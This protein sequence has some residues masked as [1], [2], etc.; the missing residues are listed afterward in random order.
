MSLPTDDSL[1]D[2]AA[3]VASHT[4]FDEHV[5]SQTELLRV[6]RRM[7]R[8]QQ[9]DDGDAF[10]ARL[11]RTPD[12]FEAFLEELIVPETWFFR[13]RQP[14]ECLRAFVQDYRRG[15]RTD[16]RLRILSIPCSSGEE[17]F[18]IAMTLLHAGLA[19]AQFQI[20]AGDISR[21]L[22]AQARTAEYGRRS[23]RGDEAPFAELVDQYLERREGERRVATGDLRRCVRFLD[24]NLISPQLLAGE[25][26]YHIIFCR[27]VLIYLH[28]EARRTALRN[29][30]RLLMPHGLLYVGH[31]ESR[32]VAEAGFSAYGSSFPSAFTSPTEQSTPPPPHSPSRPEGAPNRNDVQ[33]Q[34]GLRTSRQ[35][36]Q[37]RPRPAPKRTARPALQRRDAAEDRSAAGRT[38]DAAAPA[39]APGAQ[40]ASARRAAD[41]GDM[42][43]ARRLCTELLAA[44]PTHADALFLMALVAQSRGERQDAEQLFRRVLYLKPRHEAALVQMMLLAQQRGDE[45]S[46]ATFRRRMEH[47]SDQ[48]SD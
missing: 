37:H 41:A 33:K 24:A 22:L 39:A 46:A 26:P 13:D 2:L 40:I 47:A 1:T 21:Q 27:N 17:P 16:A 38:A 4:G 42:D 30:D 12:A 48:E 36:A 23:F 3:L 34:M 44:D 14:F 5:V 28:A 35:A 11:L 6:V 31:V 45:I 19:P 18:S 32:L 20:D 7:M 8:E 43:E 10:V 25:P 15:N 29:L 9:I